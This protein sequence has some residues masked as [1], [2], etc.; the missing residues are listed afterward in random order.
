MTDFC[1]DPFTKS[2]LIT[3]EFKY[4]CWDRTEDEIEKSS[5]MDFFKKEVSSEFRLVVVLALKT[6]IN[7]L[8]SL[9]SGH[10]RGDT[11][12]LISTAFHFLWHV[13]YLLFDSFIDHWLKH[14]GASFHPLRPA[15]RRGSWW[16]SGRAFYSRLRASATFSAALF[17]ACSSCWIPCDWLAMLDKKIR[18]ELQR[19]EA[20][21]AESER[22]EGRRSEGFG[23]LPLCS[24]VSWPDVTDAGCSR[25]VVTS[26][27][28][29]CRVWRF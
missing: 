5:K 25:D 19:I 12:A 4:N 20:E 13:N 8:W 11:S 17:S 3:V 26:G 6:W 14:F 28:S 10:G 21:H 24:P 1:I 23:L 7:N 18:E 27:E 29:F 15:R 22:N 16:L 9:Q 2:I